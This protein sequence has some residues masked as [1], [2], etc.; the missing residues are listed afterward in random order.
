M[1][2]VNRLATDEQIQCTPSKRDG[3]PT[4][5]EEE[6]RVYACR[7]IQQAGILLRLPQAA[8]ATAQVILHRFWFVSSMKQFDVRHVAMGALLLATKQV[9]VPV[10][11]RELLLVFDFLYQRGLHNAKS[12]PGVRTKES[13]AGVHAVEANQEKKA[14]PI[15]KY[16]ACDS[17]STTM[18]DAKDA[19]MVAEMQIL[20]RL[21]FHVQVELP[22]ALMINYMQVMGILEVQLASTRDPDT[23]LH[24]PQIAWNYLTDALQ[25]PVYCLFPTHVIACASIYLMTLHP[26][27][28][29]EPLPLPLQPRPWWEVLDCTRNELRTVAA[30]ILRLYDTSTGGTSRA[31]HGFAVRVREDEGGLVDIASRTG[32]RAWLEHK[33]K[34][35]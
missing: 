29:H 4:D 10:R 34:N 35:A 1:Q 5:V 11:L 15:F 13:H 30:Y 6:V 27:T 8:M 16:Q 7:Q 23:K 12:S 3:I 22:Y 28:L 14:A 25:T 24:A 9:E 18:Y 33:E 31:G 17:H 32:I 20:K 2:P 19:V 21:G 26:N